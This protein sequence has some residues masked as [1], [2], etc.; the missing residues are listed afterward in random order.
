MRGKRGL[1]SRADLPMFGLNSKLEQRF[2]AENTEPLGRAH[3]TVYFTRQTSGFDD[4][5]I[6]VK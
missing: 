6:P 4:Y 1:A 5:G 3:D 2:M